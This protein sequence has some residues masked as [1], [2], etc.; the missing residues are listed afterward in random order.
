MKKYIY[1]R[2]F[3]NLI[4]LSALIQIITIGSVFASVT[5]P[6]YKKTDAYSSCN[7]KQGKDGWYFMYKS[8]STGAYIDMTWTDNHFKGLGGGNINE[9]FI[10][11]GYDAPAVIGWEAPYTGT[12]TLTAQD[13][14][15]Y[16]NGPYPTGEDVIATM[17]LN[18]EILTDDNGKETRW[19][20]DNTCY[21][22][23]GNQSYTV[24]N[25]HINKGD[26]I[27]HEVDCGKNC[28][29][30]AIYW[31]P[32]I[33]YTARETIP[34]KTQTIYK[35][36]DAYMDGNGVQ[37]Y[38]G[39]F[40]LKRNKESNKYTYLKWDGNQYSL[41]GAYV[42][43]H[44][45][46]PGYDTPAVLCWKAPYS[47]NINLSV[48]DDVVYRNGPNPNGS[49]VTATLRL[50]DE[51]LIGNNGQKMQWVFDNAC[52]NGYGNQTY[53]VTNLH[54]NKGDMLYHE[55]DCGTNM[56]GAGVYW[57]PIVEYTE[58]D[59]DEAEQNTYFI[60]TITDYK[61]YADIV[62]STNP[63]AC[64]KLMT[65]IEFNRNTPQ[66]I[67]FEGI[68]D[69]NNHKITLHGNS[70]IESAKNG[71]VIKNLTLD[72][73]VR[74]ENNA[75][76]F[77]GNIDAAEQGVIIKNCAN[78]ANIYSS[79]NSAAGFVGYVGRNSV[80]KIKSS[81]NYGLIISMG[82]TANAF[83]NSDESV[84]INCENSYYL[85]DCTKINETTVINTPRG[86]QASAKRFASGEIAYNLNKSAGDIA[87]GQD[88]GNNLYPVGISDAKKVVYKSDN[89]YKNGE[90]LFA[91]LGVDSA[92]FCADQ[93]AFIVIADY[94]YDNGMLV[95]VQCAELDANSIYRTNLTEKAENVERKMFVCN[96][97]NE[98]IPLC[99]SIVYEP[100]IDAPDSTTIM[101]VSFD[102]QKTKCPIMLVDEYPSI[103]IE[104]IA[105]IA[106]GEARGYRLNIGDIQL[107]YEADNRLAK[108][109]DGHLM[110]ERPPKLSGGRLYVPVSSLMPTTGWTVEYKRFEDLIL[111]E[112]GTNYPESQ[113]TVYVKDY[114]TVVNDDD[115]KR[116]AVVRAFKAA[117][118]F[119]EAGI[120]TT[121]EFETG[122]MYKI[123]EKQ[124]AFALLDLDNLSN[125]TIEGNGCTIVF[126]RPTNSF[127]NIEGCTNIKINNIS[128]E[129]NE[130]IIIYGNVKSKNIEE[131][132]INIEIP[133]DSPLPADESWAQFYCTNPIDGQWI[134]GTFMN[135]EKAIPGFMPFDALMIKT[136]EKVQDR[137]Y[138]VT[139]KDSISNYASSINVGSRFVFKSRWNSYD[140]GENNKYG[141]PDFLVVSHSKDITFDGIETNGS[142]LMLAPVSYCDGRITFRNCKMKPTNGD[143]ITSAADGIHLGTNRFGVIV[144][145]CELT[146]SLD[147]LIN[148][149]TYC[150]NVEKKI[151]ECIFETSR[152]MF[153]RIGDE[154]KFFDTENHEV[155]GSAFL[156]TIE[157]TDDGKYRLTLDRAVDG[158]VSLEEANSPT[159]VYN[160]NAANSGNIIKNNIFANSRRH[161]YI[162]RSANSIIENNYMENNAGAATEA[163]NEIHGGVNEGLFPSSLTFRNNTVKSEGISSKYIP[164]NIYS[165][166]A[167]QG[168]QKAIDGVLIENNTID[169][170][171]VNG[172]IRINSVNGLYMLNNTIKSNAE[173]D[174]DVSPITISNSNIAQIDG[175]DFSYKQNVSAVINITGCEVNENDITNIKLIGENTAMPYSIK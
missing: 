171:S 92:A 57:K 36:T 69:G 49:D 122:K 41:D 99:E 139:F 128:V 51:I 96:N 8:N 97:S 117:A 31:K 159:V 106:G 14:T 121:L 55:V 87:F 105:K 135:S 20:F 65:D 23:S 160:M 165:W 12:V 104:D 148:T 52:Y 74:A 84:F 169:V 13:N 46:S 27:Y 155:I 70:L 32:I 124:D 113:M 174:R 59:S 100:F 9:H 126:E 22:G 90:G 156:K 83:A 5:L 133:D 118:A 68:I 136:I 79:C 19:V 95:S 143:L 53:K 86:T 29:G 114:E 153:C 63:S 152:D 129:Y 147:D 94:D 11:P 82:N 50:N 77:I 37:G 64:A 173:F 108:Y 45:I 78:L 48:Q 161:A 142:L 88:I 125:F 71:V 76:A 10:S 24:T 25:L 81:Y 98:I 2:I 73:T 75:A 101:T 167:R 89:E 33:T 120:P 3:F 110:L 91:A 58:F 151:D 127:I 146:N 144:E 134:F 18:N 103:A 116:D 168:D 150:G 154:I 93:K 149:Q 26:M 66:L 131:N 85:S 34:D 21:N 61:N 1:R 38:N 137:E 111:I 15:V 7:G 138:R 172:S 130:R 123:S 17:K 162:I 72:G 56:T 132:S 141:R 67:N 35:K 175:V 140:F 39:W 28:T 40:Y 166:N 145:N 112:T 30:A 170:P 80:L 164:F 158:I 102:G 44:F 60:N 43:E 42:N 115:D 119:A 163:A 62:N 47:G 107:E 54:V 4:V 109:G 6:I 157:R 16:R